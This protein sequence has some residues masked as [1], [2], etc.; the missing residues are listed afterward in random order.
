M[1]NN[2]KAGRKTLR[3]KA[4]STETATTEGTSTGAFQNIYLVCPLMSSH[5]AVD[6]ITVI[7]PM[8]NQIR[9]KY[10]PEVRETIYKLRSEQ[11][12][13]I[14]ISTVGI[15][16]NSFCRETDK[17]E[18]ERIIEET[19]KKMKAIDPS[20]GAVVRFVPIAVD[21]QA[22]GEIYRQLVDAI[23]GRMYE[24]L[25][26]RL[27]KLAEKKTISE[28]SRNGLLSMLKK[29]EAWNILDDKDLATTIQTIREKLA[30]AT[31]QAMA[32]IYA[33]I[34]NQIDDL[35]SRGAFLEVD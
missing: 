34:S 35:K 14:R 8:T 32:P 9:F 33:D 3:G 16:G 31:E 6:K 19:D 23:R 10:G 27:K 7:D 21:M 4:K 22:R 17:S 29:L 30:E 15:Y 12:P 18:I 26:P 1:G 20:L 11:K 2:I 13:K 25:L 24:E 5:S 28:K